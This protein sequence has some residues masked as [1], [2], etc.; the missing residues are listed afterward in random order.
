M[1]ESRDRSRS[2]TGLEKAY[3]IA[4]LEMQLAEKNCSIAILEHKAASER[5]VLDGCLVA[6]DS[7]RGRIERL[8]EQVAAQDE[9]IIELR[10]HIYQLEQRPEPTVP[11][12]AVTKAALAVVCRVERCVELEWLRRK[13]EEQ[14]TRSSRSSAVGRTS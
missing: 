12:L 9:S 10:E 11:P 13:T 6:L 14:S 8:K 1:A 7:Q 5:L 2:P 4:H 3:K